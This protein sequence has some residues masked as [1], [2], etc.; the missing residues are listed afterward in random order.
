VASYLDNIADA[1]EKMGYVKEA[2]EADN[3]SDTLE[4]IIDHVI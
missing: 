3:V 1:L 4:R 2:F